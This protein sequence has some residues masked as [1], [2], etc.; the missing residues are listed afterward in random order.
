[1]LQ[2]INK[3]SCVLRKNEQMNC[4]SVSEIEDITKDP[5]YNLIG[6]GMY[7]MKSGALNCN[8]DTSSNDKGK[9]SA[10]IGELPQ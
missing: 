5:S 6:I 10:R 2:Y 8:I 1:M 4:R 7:N 9:G 3:K